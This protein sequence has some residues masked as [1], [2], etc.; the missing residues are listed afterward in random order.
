MSSARSVHRAAWRARRGGAALL[1]ACGL[2]LAGCSSGGGPQAPAGGRPAPRSTAGDS[3]T[4]G[5]AA[6][7]ALR[8]LPAATPAALLPYYRQKLAWHACDGSFEC[9]TFRVPLDYAR[10]GA[11]DLTL[12]AARKKATGAGHARVGSLLLNPGGPGGSA[13]SYLEG[14]A[15]TFAAPVRA[16]YDLVGFDPRGVGRSS[17][18]QCLAGPRMDA[19]A[20][21]DTTPDTPAEVDALVRLDREFAAGCEQRSGRSLPHVGTVDAARDMD[22]LRALLGDAK[23]HYLGKS[24]GTYLGAVYAGLFPGRVGRMVLD[25]AL[26]PSLDARRA[27]LGQ[28]SG[29]ETAWSSFARDCVTHADCPFG[30]TTAAAGRS[31]DALLR[32]I[33]RKPLPAGGGRR[34]TEALATTGVIQAMY[35]DFLWPQLRTAAKDALRG[36]GKALMALADAYY[37]RRSD[38]G[39]D[40]LMYA[41][42][43]VNCLDMSA[44]FPGP[45]QVAAAVPAFVRA[46]PHFGRA[47]AW[48]SLTC[49]YWPVKSVGGPRTVTAAGA[50]PIVVVGTTRDPATPYAWARSLAAQLSSGRLVTF[51]GDGHTAY[52]N[53][54]DCVDTAVNTYLLEGEAPPEDKTCA[55]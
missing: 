9:A 27:A 13:V 28:A 36:D 34:L 21:A 22:V 35:A 5:S 44:P 40:N 54:S 33:D 51:R 14:V 41:N 25:G 38:G 49:A 43:A 6:P 11:G 17:P 31:L 45:R 42:M 37:E 47:M 29:F 18:V 2:L 24:Y 8:P 48:M 53:R 3:V 55:S 30:R 32:S 39:Y 26:D 19:Y 46:S 10:P 15:G 50:P 16:A 7:T 20:A 52:G 4:P 23:L 12:T 1:A